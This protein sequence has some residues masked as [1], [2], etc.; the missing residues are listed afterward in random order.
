MWFEI[1]I[2]R[3]THTILPCQLSKSIGNLPFLN[4]C[5]IFFT[6]IER[7]SWLSLVDIIDYVRDW[8]TMQFNS[9]SKGNT[10][11]R[12]RLNW[13]IY[14]RP[15]F[16]EVDDN[17][18]RPPEAELDEHHPKAT[19]TLFVGNLEKDISNQELRERFLKFGDILVCVPWLRELI[20]E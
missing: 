15:C 10:F 3:R 9:Y 14:F 8:S 13:S 5:T 2:P 7:W 4:C 11:M 20:Q 1:M 19:R 17:E 12:I 6:D 18:F 16:T